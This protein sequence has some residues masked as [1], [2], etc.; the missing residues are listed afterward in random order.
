M[1]WVSPNGRRLCYPGSTTFGTDLIRGCGIIMV[2]TAWHVL[3]V[4]AD[5]RK[6]TKS[7]DHERMPLSFVLLLLHAVVATTQPVRT[8]VQLSVRV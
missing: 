8:Q 2:L 1:P 5:S 6:Q 4:C 7:F 3:Q